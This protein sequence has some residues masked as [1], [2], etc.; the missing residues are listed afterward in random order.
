M[1]KLIFGFYIC[2]IVGRTERNW[3]VVFVCFQGSALKDELHQK[4]I[5]VCVDDSCRCIGTEAAPCS[6]AGEGDMAQH[7]FVNHSFSSLEK[8]DGC[9]KYIRGLL[10]Q[11]L[12]C[13]GQLLTDIRLL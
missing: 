13:Q 11:G 7:H 8:C 4:T 9:G 5:F 6:D 12:I 1:L 2:I 10:H 3:A